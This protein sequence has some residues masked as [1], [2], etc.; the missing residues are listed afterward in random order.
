M[1][2]SEKTIRAILIDDEAHS[3]DS[4]EIELGMHCPE[5]EVVEKCKG[6]QAGIQSI[7]NKNPDLIF[8]DI[9][10]PGM[11]GFQLLEEVRQQDFEVIFT[12]AYDEYAI[13]AIKVSALDYLLKPIDVSELKKAVRKIYEKKEDESANQKLDVLLTNIQSNGFE[14]LAIPTLKGLD[15][16][17]VRDINYCKADGNYTEIHMLDGSNYVISKT[18]K[19]TS[20]LLNNSSFY[21]THQSYLVN[22]NCIK[23]Y[24]KGS[25]GQLVMQNNDI[26][27]VARARKEGLMQVIYRK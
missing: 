20:S 10:M 5:V 22:L 6:A 1:T 11:N 19:E 4:L 12:T 9:E 16:I 26:V 24:I 2:Q 21:R 15:F 17:T 13:K 7:Y 27:Q 8:L 18:I 25:G 14:K 23:Q 3:L